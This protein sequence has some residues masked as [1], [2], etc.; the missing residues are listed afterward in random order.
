MTS[1]FTYS[2]A[3]LPP[4]PFLPS[5]ATK[6]ITSPS[7]PTVICEHKD[8]PPR[9]EPDNFFSLRYIIFQ[10]STQAKPPSHVTSY[11]DDLVAETSGTSPFVSLLTQALTKLA[12]LRLGHIVLVAV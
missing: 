11:H 1:D 4:V 10:T 9:V 5:L 6:M 8:G 3:V 12:S 2:R 7:T